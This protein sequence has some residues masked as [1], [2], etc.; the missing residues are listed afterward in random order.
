MRKLAASLII[1]AF[2]ATAL[3]SSFFG[4][5]P[6]RAQDAPL[7]TTTPLGL[8]PVTSLALL[9]PDFEGGYDEHSQPFG[10]NNAGVDKRDRV[11]CSKGGTIGI[12]PPPERCAFVFKGTEGG[13]ASVLLQDVPIEKNFQ[14]GQPIAISATVSGK[15][16]A[17]STFLVEGILY[18]V[19]FSAQPRKIRAAGEINIATNDDLYIRSVDTKLETLGSDLNFYSG[20]GTWLRL[21]LRYRGTSGQLAVANVNANALI[22]SPTPT[23]SKTPLG[24]PTPPCACEPESRRLESRIH[25]T[26]TPFPF[27][28]QRTGLGGE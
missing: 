19:D 13:K 21:K 11:R 6:S 3:V 26:R 15:N 14:P 8:P 16:L 28:P 10:W 22:P 27:P 20:K 18:Y 12:V 2:V 7:L 25:P 9:N 5:S 24:Q 23:A 1:F 4:G 17:G